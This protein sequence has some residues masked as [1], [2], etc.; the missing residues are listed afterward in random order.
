M[1]K[2]IYRDVYSVCMC[3]EAGEDRS[4]LGGEPTCVG[5]R[6]SKSFQFGQR[7]LE[8]TVT[9]ETEEGTK[10]P[11]YRALEDFRLCPKKKRD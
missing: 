3:V 6:G 7:K 9:E 8:R 5:P 2:V 11:S 1:L 4:V 10:S